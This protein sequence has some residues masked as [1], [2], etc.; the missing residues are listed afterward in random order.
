[1]EFGV[2][3]D[4][5]VISI[6]KL[7]AFLGNDISNSLPFFHAFSG[8][9]STSGFRGKGK[10][11]IFKIWKSFPEATQTFLKIS[12][13]PFEAINISSDIFKVLERFTVLVYDKTS[14]SES[15]NQTRLN[16]F[17]K[18]SRSFENLPPTQDAL[19]LH[20][21]RAYIPISSVDDGTQGNNI[22][23]HLLI[24][25]LIEINNGQLSCFGR[26][27]FFSH[28]VCDAVGAT[29]VV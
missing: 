26:L 1:M 16:L 25:H 3:K 22:N 14:D 24:V 2:G 11:T 28:L 6:N 17:C 12:S 10:K 4:L 29:S 21:L 20:V 23:I 7:Y 8:S 5:K 18:K 9:D 19:F 13:N 15:V 27:V